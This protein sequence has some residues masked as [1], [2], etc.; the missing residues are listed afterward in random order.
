ML[1]VSIIVIRYKYNNVTK[2]TTTSNSRPSFRAY[3]VWQNFINLLYSHRRPWIVS[4][5]GCT[6]II[7]VNYIITYFV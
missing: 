7:I 6:S 3:V 5:I 1:Y 4:V 2:L